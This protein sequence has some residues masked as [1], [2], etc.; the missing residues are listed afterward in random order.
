MSLMTRPETTADHEAIRH[1]DRIAFGQDAEARLVDA[2]RDGGYVRASLVAEQD[3]NRKPPRRCVGGEEWGC[4][5]PAG[6]GRTRR[7]ND[8]FLHD[9]PAFATW[10]VPVL[11]LGFLPCLVD[12]DH[13]GPGTIEVLL[14]AHFQDK[15]LAWSTRR[16]DALTQLTTKHGN[17]PMDL[18]S[19]LLTSR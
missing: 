18:P 19:G 13:I 6:L 5:R 3:G 1:V 11:F 15:L 10:I 4:S 8:H 17:E 9:L 16:H 7:T 2:L 12:D 14:S